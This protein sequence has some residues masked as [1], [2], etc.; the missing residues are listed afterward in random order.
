MAAS[1]PVLRALIHRDARP[2]RH[3]FAPSDPDGDNSRAA[4]PILTDEKGLA[5][6]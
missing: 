2:Q 6:R 1:I 3:R 4:S 5:T